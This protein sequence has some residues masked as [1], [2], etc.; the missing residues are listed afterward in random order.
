MKFHS[1]RRDEVE[2]SLTPLIDVV[3]LLLIFFMVSTTFDSAAEL[4]LR[5]PEASQSEVR[6][7]ESPTEIWLTADGRLFVDGEELINRRSETLERHLRRVYGLDGDATAAERSVVLRADATAE[8]QWVVSV[9]DTLARLGVRAVA[10]ATRP[11]EGAEGTA[12]PPAGD[13]ASAAE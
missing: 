10:I 5:L 9:I 8:H 3:F 6:E 4:E 12:R 1:G 7:R 13:D 2:L 11:V